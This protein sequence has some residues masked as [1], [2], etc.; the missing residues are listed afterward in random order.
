[1]TQT[2]RR[3]PGQR[4]D[5]R[6]KG[7]I[8]LFT[9]LR[10]HEDGPNAGMVLDG[11]TEDGYVGKTRQTLAQR[12]QQHRGG[13]A[14]GEPVAGED[15]EEQPWWDVTVGGIRLVEQGTWTDDELAERERYW[16]HQI[17]PR[18]NY[19][20]NGANERRIPK[21]VAREHRDRRDRA[22]GLTP[23]QWQPF[24]TQRGVAVDPVVPAARRRVWPAVKVVLRSPWTW[25][26]VAW[27]AT[28]VTAWIAVG[29]AVDEIGQEL[30]AG[31]RLLLAT[32]LATAGV[33]RVWWWLDGR[34]RWRRFKRRFKRR[35]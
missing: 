6:R 27:A 11:T 14:D 33:G 12:E 22:K 19:I 21:P 30:T 5:V 32:A 31:W 34:K 1:V 25:W 10:I 2:A 16:I 23:R 18:Y 29:W 4:A 24:S 13:S 17:K 7:R 35:W 20:D 3:I 15:L 9:T 8:Y 26:T 28:T